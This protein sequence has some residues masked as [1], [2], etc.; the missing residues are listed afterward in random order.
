MKVSVRG[1]ESKKLGEE[2]DGR[3]KYA[4]RW[5]ERRGRNY[6]EK[7]KKMKVE[8]KLPST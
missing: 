8:R 1:K 5:T 2:K 7:D 6:T 3:H 4:G